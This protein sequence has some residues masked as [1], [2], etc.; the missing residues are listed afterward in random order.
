MASS[1]GS[2]VDVFLIHGAGGA[3]WEWDTC[4]CDDT[5]TAAMT[6][7]TA[8]RRGRGRG[9]RLHVRDHL[10]AMQE[11]AV[12]VRDAVDSV[13][14]VAPL[15]CMLHCEESLVWTHRYIHTFMLIHSH[16]SSDVRAERVRESDLWAGASRSPAPRRRAAWRVRP[17]GRPSRLR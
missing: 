11:P 13:H 15:Q 14:A 12:D 2:E 16:P 3:S 5:C 1:P 17:P 9:L 7:T 6:S 4:K 10:E 8:S